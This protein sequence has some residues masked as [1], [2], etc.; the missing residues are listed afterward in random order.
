M[1]NAGRAEPDID[2]LAQR[3]GMTVRNIRAHQSRGLLEPADVRG[4]TGLLRA[5]ARGAAGI[6]PAAPGRRYS[7][8]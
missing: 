2:Q 4:R 8:T 5:R 6:D 1:A 7:L 3:T